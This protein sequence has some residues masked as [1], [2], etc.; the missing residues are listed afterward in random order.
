MTLYKKILA[1]LLPMLTLLPGCAVKTL[2]DPAQT[3]TGEVRQQEVRGVLQNG[4]WLVARFTK[5]PDN[6]IVLLTGSPLSHTAIYD[7]EHD[8]V[9]EAD[10]KGVHP[11][12]LS[13]FLG[14]SHRVLVIRPLWSGPES[15]PQAVETARSLIGKKYNYTG[16]IGINS[17][18]RYY[19]TQLAIECYRPFI[20]EKPDNP[21][22]KIIEPGQM[23]HWGRIIYDSGPNR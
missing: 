22:P 18:E 4:D 1:A 23:Y 12:A 17:P 6:A 9:I 11:S 5:M 13:T 10:S 20:T 16:L 8:A 7:A 15:S 3:L 2:V 19:C 21:I 14:N